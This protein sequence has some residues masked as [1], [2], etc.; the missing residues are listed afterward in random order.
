MKLPNEIVSKSRSKAGG[1]G[2]TLGAMI[3]R[4]ESI[5]IRG[6]LAAEVLLIN[7]LK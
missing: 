1:E 7:R 5:D 3:G 6:M 4:S 2:H